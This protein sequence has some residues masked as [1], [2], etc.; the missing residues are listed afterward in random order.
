MIDPHVHLR[1]WFEDYKE[2]VIHGLNVAYKVGLDGVFEMPNTDPPLTSKRTIL[3]R[4]VLADK[5][6]SKLGITMFHGLYAGVTSNEKQIRNVVK[7]Y[8]DFFPRVVGLKMYAAHSTGN[9]GV[10]DEDSQRKVYRQLASLSYKGVLAVHCEKESLIQ[11]D[12]WNPDEPYSHVLARTIDSEL[13]SVEDQIKFARE[14]NFEGTLYICHVSVPETVKR[15]HKAN[16]KLS[17]QKRSLKIVCGVTPHH[18]LLDEVMML[19]NNGTMLKMN[20]P[21]RPRYMQKQILK[22]LTHGNINW[23]ETDHAP[24]TLEDKVLGNASGIPG[25]PFYPHFISYL[26]NYLTQEQLAALTHANIEHVFG[27]KIPTTP[28]KFDYGLSDEYSFN[29]YRLF[30]FNKDNCEL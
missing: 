12:L 6:I 28:R 26:T 8:H 9:L 11:H 17:K 29:P 7:V 3:E 14:E 10:I 21:L 18:A 13:V 30:A 22:H 27:I 2:T 16:R 25:F 23:I 4:I 15:I 20:P 1:D 24:H 19:A 5:A